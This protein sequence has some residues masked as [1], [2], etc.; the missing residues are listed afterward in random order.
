MRPQAVRTEYQVTHGFRAAMG[1]PGPMKFI[2]SHG[3]LE[4]NYVYSGAVHYFL[5]GKF[6]TL[7]GGGLAAFW[8]ALPHEVLDVDADT[9]FMV[10]T[11]PLA[12]L[13]RWNLGETFL[14]RILRGDVIL[15][16]RGL[17]WDPEL[18]RR[19]IT[20]LAQS[21]E[22]L[23]RTVELEVEARLRRLAR[24]ETLVKQPQHRNQQ[25]VEAI[26][27]F[28]AENFREELSTE[29]VAAAV[30]LH[31][32]YA[33][34]MFRKNCGMTIWQYLTRLRLSHAQMLLLTTDRT[35]L[36]IALEAGFGSLPRFYVAFTRECGMAPGEYRKRA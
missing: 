14:Q 16:D 18:T 5:G 12:V 29:Q 23:A 8:G 36:D 10:L 34:T 4:L 32:N 9:E 20:D 2:H 17:P 21:D 25:Q 7:P 33:M 22:T 19:W 3:D 13:L 28:L 24:R 31:P 35:I 27:K 15:D 26:T 30:N 11:V 1:V 6:I